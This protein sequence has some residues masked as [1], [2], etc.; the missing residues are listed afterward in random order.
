MNPMQTVTT[1]PQQPKLL[2]RARHVLR[3]DIPRGV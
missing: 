3:A 1:N 2:D